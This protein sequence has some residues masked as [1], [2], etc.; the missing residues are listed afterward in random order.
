MRLT[1]T[2]NQY[3][4]IS[5]LIHWLLAILIIGLIILGLYMKSLPI[6]PEKLKLYGLHKAYGFLALAL[7]MFRLP[8]RL[9]N[10]TPQLSLPWWEK[11]AARS[12]HWAFYGFMFAMPITGWLMTS[13]AGLPAS[14]FGWF[15]LPDLIGPD[16]V[17][18]LFFKMLHKWLA[19]G[20]I[21]T[22]LM[23]TSAA[24]KHHFINR[25]DI[26]RRML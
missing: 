19:Y 13:A 6:N 14:F 10:I 11:I 9:W 23:H 3:G 21:V 2:D 22:I 7:V 16:P 12:V 24:L 20:L 18:F 4:V 25:D 26:L 5:I 8:W 15:V 17:R 1:N